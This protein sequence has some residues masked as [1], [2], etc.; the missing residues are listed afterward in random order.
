MPAQS[1]VFRH[2][3]TDDGLPSSEVYY[4]I[5]DKKGYIWFATDMGVSRFDGYHF[6][7]FDIQKG[8]PSNTIFEMFEDY[9]G[10]IWFSSFSGELSYYYNDTI[11]QYPYNDK[12]VAQFIESPLVIN[13]AFF[14]DTTDKI[15]MGLYNQG[16]FEAFPDGKIINKYSEN[17]FNTAHLI[18][19]N[20]NEK[21]YILVFYENKT[22]K[23]KN[24]DITFL[25]ILKDDKLL[26]LDN[27]II[28]RERGARPYLIQKDNGNYIYAHGHYI[29]EF[30]DST[31]INKREIK[32]RVISLK[33]DK[34]KKLCVG[35][36]NCGVCFYKNGDISKPHYAHYFKNHPIACVFLDN[37]GGYWFATLDD[38]VFYLSS[39][40][41]KT[42][43][44][45]S[46]LANNNTECVVID[47]DNDIWVG[48]NDNYVNLISSDSIIKIPVSPDPNIVIKELCIDNDNLWIGTDGFIYFIPN[49]Y[50]QKKL[51]SKTGH[52]DIK[53]INISFSTKE[54]K[55][56]KKKGIW[57]GGARTLYKLID[58]NVIF[59]GNTSHNYTIRTEAIYELT[60]GDVL[61]GTLHGLYKFVLKDEKKIK[62]DFIYYGEKNELL[63]N[64]ILDIIF[65]DYNKKFWLATKG[66]GILVYSEDTVFQITKDNGLT[67][68]S[69]TSIYSKDNV[70]W[71]GTNLGLNKIIL[72]NNDPLKFDIKT[73]TVQNGLASNEVRDIQVT[74]S[75][76]YVATKSGL[77]VFENTKLPDQ[78]ICPIIYIT[79]VSIKGKDTLI[80]DS[81][82][83]P[84]NKNSITIDYFGISYK[85]KGEFLYK[86]KLTGIDEDW[87]TNKKT[88]AQYPYLPAG[89]YTFTVIAKSIS[90]DWSLIPA[91]LKID[92]RQPFWEKWWFYILIISILGMTIWAITFYKM[93]TKGKRDS[94]LKKNLSYQQLALSNQMDP[95]FVSNTLNSIQNFIMANDKIL[96]SKYLSK[97]SDLMRRTLEASK[98][99]DITLK[100]EI[101][102]LELYLDFERLRLKDKFNYEFIV[103]EK[104]DTEIVC[105]PIFIL[106]PLL[107]NSIWHGFSHKEDKCSL[108][109][110]IKLIK[111]TILCEIQDNGIGRAKAEEFR[112]KFGKD[113]KSTGITNIKKRLK[114]ISR[115]ENRRAS[116]NIDDLTDENGNSTGTKVI[117]ILPYKTIKNHNN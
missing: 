74:D 73:I 60:N 66:A 72:K 77:T 94:L 25:G 53:T 17:K 21:S 20:K 11:V 75:M 79:N 102:L 30:K 4:I 33:I 43:N 85:Y 32:D 98:K 55:K 5:Q 78:N 109:V 81:Y 10:R 41:Y 82:N 107:E 103:D 96:S 50:K 3:T 114:L 52:F 83:L 89:S 95:H 51:F 80:R 47:K 8:L 19:D 37:E 112:R 2:Y 110:S 57:I 92:I 14:V 23:L 56:S 87:V 1:P 71:A 13:G 6:E 48:T 49:I 104:I 105:I 24:S 68:N 54:F 111:K 36:R 31:L 58:K 90:G 44:K 12:L 34:Q 59:N 67:S 26:K 65:C 18:V 9:K 22:K 117:I 62:G 91:T 116:L 86:H 27:D 46:G 100:K 108:T 69:V 40:F 39:S 38:G 42:Y 29:Y 76:V 115:L 93:K 16:I 101:D 64:R 7:N 70:I 15:T 84:Y 97:F 61:L 63:K 35:L 106:Q 113:H 88:Q 45:A 28:V 99:N